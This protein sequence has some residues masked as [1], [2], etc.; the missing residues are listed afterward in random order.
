MSATVLVFGVIVVTGTQALR[1]LSIV[2]IETAL[3][4]D[5]FRMEPSNPQLGDSN[6][7]IAQ[8]SSQPKTE[9]GH[10]G[11]SQRK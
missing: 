5:R 3:S 6:A 9:R 7:L 2:S 1:L 10:T 4:A 8:E 11:V